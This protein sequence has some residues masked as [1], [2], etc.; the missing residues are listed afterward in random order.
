MTA[1]IKEIPSCM[2]RAIRKNGSRWPKKKYAKTW[3]LRA[4]ESEAPTVA[5]Q[6]LDSRQCQNNAT[7]THKET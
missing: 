7:T 6:N 4:D 3:K 1:A 5:I 2:A